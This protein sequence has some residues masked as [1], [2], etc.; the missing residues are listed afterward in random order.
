MSRRLV[1]ESEQVPGAVVAQC[2]QNLIADG[3]DTVES[4][5]RGDERSDTALIV[6]GQTRPPC[7]IRMGH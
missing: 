7:D 1:V 3:C 2:P 4:L 5:G 6:I